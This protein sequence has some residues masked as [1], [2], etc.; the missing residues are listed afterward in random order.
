MQFP[1][2]VLVTVPYTA[3]KL[4]GH[5]LAVEGFTGRKQR[6]AKAVQDANTKGRGREKLCAPQSRPGNL[7]R[8]VGHMAMADGGTSD[9][10]ERD[11]VNKGSLVVK[12]SLPKNRIDV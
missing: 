5:V 1:C 6:G 3:R 8:L 7:H 9:M 12:G 10:R 11:C 2:P 4:C